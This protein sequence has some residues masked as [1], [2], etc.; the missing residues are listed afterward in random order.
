[1][2]TVIYAVLD[3]PGFLAVNVCSSGA[4]AICTFSV[5]GVLGFTEGKGFVL[6]QRANVTIVCAAPSPVCPFPPTKS[7][8]VPCCRKQSVPQLELGQET[9]ANTPT[10]FFM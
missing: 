2:K 7:P 5:G 3:V 8:S 9:V 1:M 6:G 4:A 10:P